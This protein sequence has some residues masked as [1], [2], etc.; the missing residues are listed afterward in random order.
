MKTKYHGR[1][2]VPAF[3]KPKL[4]GSLFAL[5]AMLAGNCLASG[6][7]PVSDWPPTLD[8]SKYVHF[9]VVSNGFADVLT[10][11]NATWTNCLGICAIGAG[12][13]QGTVRVGCLGPEGFSG[14]K[15][16]YN[17]F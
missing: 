3:S 8:T 7:Y 9:G 6:P 14:L 2:L 16:G 13:D 4:I 10:S 5:A 1:G 12:A 17:Y 11:A 15:A